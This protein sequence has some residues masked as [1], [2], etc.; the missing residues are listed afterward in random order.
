MI[1]PSFDRV[2][3]VKQPSEAKTQSGIVLSQ[4]SNEATTLGRVVAVGEG[5][6]EHGV[7]ITPPVR[8]D[9]VIVFKSYAATT[10]KHEGQEM[11]IIE[12]KDIL[13]KIV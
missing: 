3:V 13:A 4:A 11:L 5:R 12:G 2:V 10:L 7:L 6:Y 9:D 1:Q 8:V